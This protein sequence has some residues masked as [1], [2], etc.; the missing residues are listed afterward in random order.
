MA[1]IDYKEINKRASAPFE[2]IDKA[3]HEYHAHIREL[4][5][6]INENDIIKIILLAGPSGSGKT[7]SAN[8]LADALR[9][10]GEDVLVVSLDDFYKDASDKTYPKLEGGKRDYECPEALHLDELTATLEKVA[11]GESFNIPKYDFKL[12]AR[13]NIKAHPPIDHGC[14][15][16]EG[17]HA[18]NPKISA[19]LP[20]DKVLKLFVSVSTNIND[21][22]ERMLSGRKLRFVRRMVRDSIYRGANAE[23]TLE[24]WQNVLHAEDI[25]LYPYKGTADIAFDTF[26]QFEPCVMAPFAKRLITQDLAKKNEYAAIVLEA[27]S[28]IKEIDAH[29]VPENSLIKEFIPGGKYESLY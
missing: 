13:V 29:L 17:L 6:R 20:K 9:E 5:A 21:G 3:E 14:V 2:M 7:T 27:L 24:M 10:L 19:S 26:H 25:Y 12:A 16:I 15:I 23:K 8:L 18:L 1:E 22:E 11:E 4:A 28:K